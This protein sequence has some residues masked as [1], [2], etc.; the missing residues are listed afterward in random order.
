M[1]TTFRKRFTKTDAPTVRDYRRLGQPA[2]C[3]AVLIEMAL[4]AR[5]LSASPPPNELCLHDVSFPVSLRVLHATEVRLLVHNEAA[6]SQIEIVDDEKRSVHRETEA[7]YF[8][9]R[10]SSKAVD[11]SRYASRLTRALAVLRAAH[12]ERVDAD[13]IYGQSQD[14]AIELGPAYRTLRRVWV[15]GRRATAKLSLTIEPWPGQRAFLLHPALVEASLQLLRWL[16]VATDYNKRPRDSSLDPARELDVA[17][18]DEIIVWRPLERNVQC[19]VHKRCRRNGLGQ[20]LVSGDIYL[21]DEEDRPLAA[22]RGI[23]FGSANDATVATPSDDEIAR[24]F[25]VPRWEATEASTSRNNSAKPQTWLLLGLGDLLTQTLAMRLSETGC[26]VAVV[27]PGTRFEELGDLGYAADP[28]S[29]DELRRCIVDVERRLG[30]IDGVIHAWGV[31]E[32]SR[33]AVAGSNRSLEIF[34]ESLRLGAGSLIRLIQA[35]TTQTERHIDLVAITTNMTPVELDGRQLRPACNSLAAVARTAGQEYDQLKVRVLDISSQDDATV[36]AEVIVG[37]MQRRVDDSQRAPVVALRCHNRYVEYLEAIDISAWRSAKGTIKP[38][39]VYLITGGQRGLGLEVARWMATKAPCRLVLVNRT[40]PDTQTG[41][42]T[43]L[44]ASTTDEY[45]ARRRVFIELESMGAEVWPVAADV[46]D[47]DAMRQLFREIDT[48]YGRLDGIV[49]AAGTLRDRTIAFLDDETWD[50]VLRPKVR[51]SWILHELSKDRPL[52]FFVLFSSLISFTCGPGQANHAAANAF[53]DGLAHWRR[54]QGLPALSINWGYWSE[55]GVVATPDYR[56][57]VESKGVFPI[58]SAAGCRAFG[59][60]LASGQT[61][62]G[63]ARVRPETVAV[64]AGNRSSKESAQSETPGVTASADV[65]KWRD[66]GS[67]INARAVSLIGELAEEMKAYRGL[68]GELDHLVGV[69]LI[70][71]F[72]VLNCLP[73]PGT[74]R[75][76]ND[77]FERAGV[78]ATYRPLFE[79]L[80]EFLA[81]DGILLRAT[82]GCWK[83]LRSIEAV[84]GQ[85][86]A[87]L[88]DARRRYPQANAEIELLARCGTQLAD[89]LR[90]IHDP[91]EVLFPDGSLLAAAALYEQ[92]PFAR[93]Y[94]LLASKAVERYATTFRPG[95]R[96]RALEIGA[97]TGGT[98]SVLL[99]QQA[100]VFREYVYTDISPAFLHRGQ[101]RIGNRT[102][103]RFQLYN[104]EGSP[105]SQVLQAHVFDLVI[106]ANVLHATRAIDESLAH[107]RRLLA[108]G[109]MLLILETVREKRYAALTFA[110]TPGWWRFEDRARRATSPLLHESAWTLALADAGFIASQSFPDPT[111]GFPE[112][113]QRL[114]VALAP[115]GGSTEP[116][117][118]SST[119]TVASVE[120]R[121]HAQVAPASTAAGSLT[122]K[123]VRMLRETLAD[124]LRMPQSRLDADYPFQELGL[125]SLL[126]L[127]WIRRLRARLGNVRLAPPILFAHPTLRGLAAHLCTEQGEQLS[128]AMV[129]Q[130]V[131]AADEKISRQQSADSLVVPR[132]QTAPVARTLSASRHEDIAVVGYALRVP[133]ADN[134]DAFWRMLIDGVDAVGPWPSSRVDDEVAQINAAD[135]GQAQGGFLRDVTSFD[136]LFFRIS[137]TEAARME[138]RQRLFL[139]TA[140]HALEHAGYGGAALEG[141]RTGVFVGA[142]ATVPL[143]GCERD[144]IDEHWAS[145][146]TPSILASRIAYFLNLQGPVL[147]VDTACSSSLVALHLAV[148]SLR[149]A[150]CSMALAGGVHLNVRPLNFA[151]FERMGAMARDHR[152]KAFDERADGFVPG[153][154]VGSVVLRPLAEALA[155]GDT[156]YGVIK[157]SATNN[158]GRSNGL[159][160][161]N[162][163]A[164]R[165]VLL[166]AWQDAAVEPATVS[167]IEAHGTGTALGDPIEVEGI[168]L[169]FTKHTRRHQF[170]RIGAVKSN[171]GHAEPAAGMVS[172]IKV[173]LALAHERLPATLHLVEPNR[174]LTFENSPLLPCDRVVAWPRTGLPRRAGVSAFGLSGTNVHVVIEEAPD[175]TFAPVTSSRPEL[176]VLSARSEFALRRLVAAHLRSLRVTTATL[177][178]ICFTLQAG[179]LHQQ[180]RLAMVASSVGE[181]RAKLALLEP[182]EQ[183]FTRQELGIF[184][185]PAVDGRSETNTAGPAASAGEP[186]LTAELAPRASG[187]GATSA[188]RQARLLALAAR[189]AAGDTLDWPALHAQDT[190]RRR[191][192][193]PLYPFEHRRHAPGLKPESATATGERLSLNASQTV[194][195]ARETCAAVRDHDS[196]VAG[197]FHRVAWRHATIDGS[198]RLEP[199][200]WLIFADKEGVASNAASRLITLGHNVVLVHAGT[201]FAQRGPNDYVINPNRLDH[202]A[203]LVRSLEKFR[204]PWQGVVHAWNVDRRSGAATVQ[205][206]AEQRVLGVE[207]LLTAVQTVYVGTRTPELWIVT[208][209]TQAIAER[210][211]IIPERAAAWGF[212]RALRHELPHARVRLVDLSLSETDAVTAAEQLVAEITSASESNESAWHSHSRYEPFEETISRRAG[213]SLPIQLR[214]DATYLVTGGQEG[215]G[216]EIARWFVDQGCRRLVLLNRTPLDDRPDRRQGLS[217]LAEAGALVEPVRGD[218][219]DPTLL[220]SVFDKAAARGLPIAGV[221]HAAAVS[222]DRQAIHLSLEELRRVFKPKVCGAY[223]LDQLTREFG[224]DFLVLFS[225]LAG[226]FGQ[227]GQ[228]AY[229]AASS[230]L[231]AL[232]DARQSSA[233]P[234]VLSLAWGP[235]LDVGIAARAFTPEHLAIGGIEGISP[236]M[237]RLLFPAAFELSLAHLLVY[238][239][240]ATG[241]AK[242]SDLARLVPPWQRTLR[243]D[244]VLQTHESTSPKGF[245]DKSLSASADATEAITAIVVREAAAALGITPEEIQPRTNFQELGLDSMLAVRVANR[246]ASKLGVSLAPT[247]LFEQANVERL[248]RWLAD[249]VRSTETGASWGK[250]SATTI[251]D[252]Q[253]SVRKAPADLLARTATH[254]TPSSRSSCGEQ[255]VA[256]IGLACRFPGARDWRQYWSNQRRGIDTIREVP[257]D[258]WDWRE[259]LDASGEQLGT[260]VSR[261]GGFVDGVDKFD[262][263][264]FQLSPR[265]VRWMDPQQRLLLE[266]TWEAFETAGYAPMS[267]DSRRVGVFVGVSGVEYLH[268]LAGAG[269][270][271]D[272]HTGSGNSLTMVANRLSYFFDFVGPSLAIDTACSSSLVAVHQACESLA[273]GD[274]ELALAGGVNLILTPGGTII[275]S[276]AGMLSSS[277]RCRTFD[278]RADGYVRSEGAGLVLL[279][280]LDSALRDGDDIWAVIRGSAVNHDGHQK[281]GLTAPNPRSQCELLTSAWRRA[282]ITP[283]SL[284][285]FEAH[286]TG[287][288]LGDPLEIK[289]LNEA[290]DQYTKAKGHCAIG[291]AKSFIGH[292]EAAAG[293]AGLIRAVLALRRRELPPTIHF[294]A[295]NHAVAFEN[296]AVYIN[297]RLRE[298]PRRAFGARRAAVS[299]FG[300]GGTNA[301]L[302]LEEA[303]ASAEVSSEPDRPWHV[304]TLSAKRPAALVELAESYASAF[305]SEPELNI[306]NV[307]FTANTGRQSFDSRLAVVGQTTADLA[308]SLRQWLES[309]Q[310]PGS[311]SDSADRAN[312]AAAATTWSGL[313]RDLNDPTTVS[314]FLPSVLVDL[315]EIPVLAALRC[316]CDGEVFRTRVLPCLPAVIAARPRMEDFTNDQWRQLL[317][318]LARLYAHGVY[319]RWQEFDQLHGRRRIVLPTYPFARQRYWV[320]AGASKAPSKLDSAAIE[321]APSFIDQAKLEVDLSGWIHRTIWRPEP[322]SLIGASTKPVDGNWLVVRSSDSDA[323]NDRLA[324][325]LAAQLR[326][327]GAQAKL[328]TAVEIESRFVVHDSIDD[329]LSGIIYAWGADTHSLDDAQAATALPDDLRHLIRLSQLVANSTASSLA[330][331]V[332]T[333]GAHE[334]LGDECQ[335]PL[336]AAASGLARV[337]ALEC[338]NLHVASVDV[339]SIMTE[340]RGAAWFER[341]SAAIIDEI[342]SGLPSPEIA[343][344]AGNRHV[345]DTVPMSAELATASGAIG[346]KHR[347]VYLI[348]G[349]LGG[350]GL[351]LA[352]WLAQRYAARLVLVGRHGL[353]PRQDWAQWLSMH[354]ADD[355]STERIRAVERLEQLG[356][357]VVVAQSDVCDEVVMRAVVDRALEKFGRLDGVFHAAGVLH[358]ALLKRK[359][360]DDFAAVYRPKVGGALVLDH[361]T[362]D[363]ALDFT[364]YFSSVASL[365][366]NIFQADYTAASRV[367]DAIAAWRTARNRRTLSIDWGLWAEAGVAAKAARLKIDEQTERQESYRHTASKLAIDLHDAEAGWAAGI[368]PMSTQIAIAALE[369]A[370]PLELS[371]VVI[372][373]LNYRGDMPTKGIAIG[374]TQGVTATSASASVERQVPVGSPSAY[375][376]IAA[377]ID[378]L[379]ER[380]SRALEIPLDRVDPT[381]PTLDLGIDSILSAQLTRQLNQAAGTRF[382]R[383]LFFDYRNLEALATALVREHNITIALPHVAVSKS[384]SSETVEA[385]APSQGASSAPPLPHRF[386]AQEAPS[387]LQHRL[388]SRK[389]IAVIGMQGRFPRAASVDEY[390]R[391]L[392]DGVDCITDYPADRIGS[393]AAAQ[394]GADAASDCG[395]FLQAIDEFDPALF[396]LSRREAAEMDPQQRFLLEITWQALEKAGYGGAA[397][398]ATRTGVFVAAMA[399][400]YLAL[401]GPPAS[402]TYLATGSAGAIIASRVSF[403]LNLRGPCLTVDT[404]CS[405]ALVA[406][407]LAIESLRRG[408]SEFALVAGV[409]VGLS[410]LHFEALRQLRAISPSGRCRT[411]DRR[412]DGYVPGEGAAVV[413]LRPLEQAIANGD[414]VLAVIR[415]SALNHGGQTAGLT[416]P[417]PTAQAEVIRAALTDSGLTAD[418]LGYIEAH[419]TG[420]E[421]G[422]P[423]EFAG[424]SKAFSSDTSR[425]QFCGLGTVKTNIGHLEAAAGIAGLIKTILVLREREL[426]PNLHLCDIN[427]DIVA[428]ESPFF[429]LD[430]PRT[431]LV[432]A[433]V[434]RR[435]AVSSF[436]FGGTNAHVIVEEAPPNVALDAVVDERTYHLVN[437]SAQSRPQLANLAQRLADQV[438]QVSDTSLADACYTLRNGR[439]RLPERLAIVARDATTAADSL[440]RAAT[441]LLSIQEADASSV[442]GICEATKAPDANQLSGSVRYRRARP[443]YKPKV[444]VLFTGAMAAYP[445]MGR[446]LY[447]TEPKF[448]RALDWAAAELHP[449][450][451]RSLVDALYSPRPD[452]RASHELTSVP[453][454]AKELIRSTTARLSN[455]GD[456]QLADLIGIAF[457]YALHEMFR[458]WG[459]R[460]TAYLGHGLGEY[461]AACAAGV[462]S[463]ADGLRLVAYRAQLLHTVFPRS[464]VVAVH[465]DAAVVRDALARF[466][467]GLAVAAENAPAHTIVV[468]NHDLLN[469]AAA[470]FIE[471]GWRVEQLEDAPELHTQRVATQLSQ[472]TAFAADISHRSPATTLVSNL[473]GAAFSE[474][475][476]LNPAYWTRH[477]S[478]TIRFASGIESLIAQGYDA[479][480]ELGADVVLS[481]W[482]SSIARR[483]PSASD[484]CFLPAIARNRDNWQTVLAVLAELATRGGTIDWASFDEGRAR[485]RVELPTYP[486]AHER[487]WLEHSP[488]RKELVAP[489]VDPESPRSSDARSSAAK[490]C[491][492]SSKSISPE[493]R[494]YRVEWRDV[495][496]VSRPLP[497][498]KWLIFDDATGVAQHLVRQ[499]GARGISAIR[500]DAG[501]EF[502]RVTADS[503]KLRFD[504]VEDYARLVAELDENGRRPAVFVTLK[505]LEACGAGSRT[506]Q[507]LER[508]LDTT[509]RSLVPLIQALGAS[510]REAE[511]CVVT[512]GGQALSPA[513]E[514]NQDFPRITAPVNPLGAM[515]APLVRAAVVEYPRLA[516][517]LVDVP[518]STDP[519]DFAAALVEELAS[520]AAEGLIVHRHGATRLAPHLAVCDLS[521]APS[522]PLRSDGFYLIAGGSGSLGLQAAH[523][524]ISMAHRQGMEHLRLLLVSRTPLPAEDEWPAILALSTSDRAATLIRQVLELRALGAVVQP[525]TADLADDVA[526]RRAIDVAISAMGPVRGVVH[527]AGH[528]QDS[529]LWR[530]TAASVE[531]VLHAKVVGTWALDSATYDQPL[532]FFV[533]F[534]SLSALRG[535][536]G[537]AVYAAA[538]AFQDAWAYARAQR[539][540]TATAVNWGPWSQSAAASGTRYQELLRESGILGLTNAEGRAAF[541]AVLASI[542]TQVAVFR[543][544]DS[545][546]PDSKPS[547][548]WRAACAAA[549][550]SLRELL[551]ESQRQFETWSEPSREIDSLASAFVSAALHQAGL[552]HQVGERVTLADIASR[553]SLASRFRHH[554]PV[555]L[556]M[557]VKDDYLSQDA[558]EAYSSRRALTDKVLPSHVVALGS[559]FPQLAPHLAVLTR[560]GDRLGDILAG[561]CNPLALL[562]PHGNS[563]DIQAVYETSP[564]PALLS[565]VVASALR[566]GVQAAQVSYARH[567]VSPQS[568]RILEIGG[569]TG[570]TTRV[571]LEQLSA[572]AIG[573]VEYLFTDLSPTLVE[574]T[575][576]EFAGRSEIRFC[577]LDIERDPATQGIERETCDVIVAANVLH[578]TRRLD[579]SLDHC[580]SLLRPGGLLIVIEAV[581]SSRFG[582]LT[583]ALTDGWWRFDDAPLRE[584]TPL[585]N[586]DNWRQLLRQHGFGDVEV[587]PDSV[588][589]ENSSSVLA[590][591]DLR[592]FLA[593]RDDSPARSGNAVAHA[594]P[595][596]IGRATSSA[597]RVRSSRRLIDELRDVFASVLRCRADQVD[598]DL[599]FQDLGLDSLSALEILKL[600]SDRLSFKAL[601]PPL[602][603]AYPT[604]LQL[605]EYL[606]SAHPGLVATTDSPVLERTKQRSV[607]ADASTLKHNV[608]PDAGATPIA[609]I[610][611]AFRFP[612]ASSQDE[613][614]DHLRDGVDCVGPVP[615]QRLDLA[616]SPAAA[617][618]NTTI[619]TDAEGG[620]LEGV[621]AFDAAF[622]RIAPSE[623]TYLDPRQRQFLET[624]YHALEHAGYGGHALSGSRTGVFVGLGVQ[625]YGTSLSSELL[626]EYSATGTSPATLASRLAYFLDLRGP[627]VP[628]DTACSSSL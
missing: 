267:P 278:A 599:P 125:D 264:L 160:A 532:D 317:E 318:M 395:G 310:Q 604:I 400:E 421:L 570:G 598:V 181:L 477:G 212:A 489:E 420:T 329:S 311:S 268:L 152:A 458:E 483:S 410:P 98:S 552:F 63:I 389:D 600:L 209:D 49:H 365:T 187:S 206:L 196:S 341:T 213:P 235:W 430:R 382:P 508:G 147:T 614:W 86:T 54:A 303:P 467:S 355:V 495:P 363:L 290:F 36:Q 198:R 482:G 225:S 3:P 313:A 428:D 233:R 312:E 210:T 32:W 135:G 444:A 234:R 501:Q 488:L 255:P 418:S 559:R 214:R 432:P 563:D 50:S 116:A 272:P 370:L 546:R 81:A 194:S 293:I 35:I 425:R 237:G 261:W 541:E 132:K 612:H 236:A 287:T 221:V 507:E 131:H 499:L 347:G 356:A 351:A 453:D 349:G 7:T 285:Y 5:R 352:E 90:G 75:A 469:M 548:L 615:A 578:A 30:P 436:G 24:W 197:W 591:L 230:Y 159:T 470:E 44:S 111:N 289:G 113:G 142:G 440:R 307:C 20:S 286:G 545:I 186:P 179:R 322:L 611:M 442:T 140:Y 151:A 371:R 134:S 424:L 242:Q 398:T 519:S 259:S 381:Q 162:P 423:I 619:S 350:I 114:I 538:N 11:R 560:C 216:L 118:R 241:R 377:V 169:A 392:R 429:L 117:I 582:L 540:A 479:F 476:K 626:C 473:T 69:L 82:G 605:A 568:F 494:T 575:R 228:T 99:A 328:F 202:V 231:D 547:P 607:E 383:T 110:L 47:F 15:A 146:F 323:E 610:G 127:D 137:P 262:A 588:L 2:A 447:D 454:N 379:C 250:P 148:Q 205:E 342:A 141:S 177:A 45:A 182:W 176:F 80:L 594:P 478:S 18:I 616:R 154:A 561:R 191:V 339:D 485:R 496:T 593:R 219:A 480:I 26:R 358:N 171:V 609:V 190:P 468:G 308:Q 401:A 163:V 58:D 624:A 240:S 105:E 361:V 238:S 204:L 263:D 387:L 245:T 564:A 243:A 333:R 394:D 79:R 229:A 314:K 269:L 517:R 330:L 434:P 65:S 505:S 101:E 46:A 462:M 529:A 573:N 108:P 620:F 23:T 372:A 66:I 12:G 292:L 67:D 120:S 298:W 597:L 511:L 304:L 338:P 192:P 247:L 83:T 403:L 25:F 608:Q 282:G 523:S 463:W 486:F 378:W 95:T 199:G 471:R 40:S 246:L 166:S 279:K 562:F 324:D 41:R 621:A 484:V 265:E 500:V 227:H 42:G 93:F 441:A 375:P 367:L 504:Q 309:H 157:G 555:L 249:N 87:A 426:P 89:V 284:D 280:P 300:F 414:Q 542:P 112:T 208:S 539:G 129:G 596:F 465:A 512:A 391:N 39:G 411:F 251:S 222:A 427:P 319:V 335:S 525:A 207:S 438:Q 406:L 413:L 446:L 543:S 145:G 37:E 459:V 487:C 520:A 291:S 354:S 143:T 106:A 502:I 344:V 584:T 475:D 19:I 172:L 408:E 357:T 195:P 369:R 533:L 550:S 531:A 422:D 332:V 302:V 84:A 386:D 174:H 461:A 201:E 452:G 56:G 360:L 474:H 407:H 10:F 9:G 315:L 587:L 51:G 515:L 466:D 100:D 22:L 419:G 325:A 200:V 170:C 388:T 270:H 415:G 173:L 189:Y 306:A 556:A 138:P 130:A 364:V 623:A 294:D 13:L 457:A 139:E 258:R 366:G 503:Y 239:T 490:E 203:S 60:A 613:F 59:W 123:L 16:V 107:I 521:P 516:T 149:R 603:F 472:L 277:G 88:A 244:S 144:D 217:T 509:I 493:N 572:A 439:A 97:G 576:I 297:D 405:S 96:L 28:N 161:P 320:E 498:G 276:Q 52:D 126:A 14:K 1:P 450:L 530:H 158:D 583:F 557:L 606:A 481:D 299:S 275:C 185:G 537:H 373:R 68:D 301:H 581:E 57:A 136:P 43:T 175:P 590:G 574:R 8:Y 586:S 402:G 571:L 103:V 73:A 518:E 124:V 368:V 78:Q 579:N 62:L 460:A 353:P 345:P 17:S 256:V 396:R 168:T 119:P 253:S 399:S 91:V 343:F 102:N 412:A 223:L 274:A 211:L 85:S 248:S 180:H 296:S 6:A 76:G 569:G 33:S 437:L 115:G 592:L 585:L 337:V 70:D 53:L 417:N 271:L 156:I 121:Q 153:E 514:G 627:A 554:L 4:A 334:V 448:R 380:V 128:Q 506:R 393:F 295:P 443:R 397:L 595:R 193:L 455:L 61:H 589:G 404:A 617:G 602:L 374:G 327:R 266:L 566:D 390:W 524:L 558:P 74:T 48:R 133:G 184:A 38:H 257:A 55:T 27:R 150:E 218:V 433:G 449:Q 346:L 273:R 359:S 513:C 416:V 336:A 281:A 510:N 376:S 165:D 534:S 362:R 71:A 431:W 252:A 435:A 260:S 628:V 77:I 215:L 109:G 326:V 409:Q 164:Q 492:S 553:L 528:L 544:A 31:D 618:P 526:L 183:R 104:V 316:Y 567:G 385:L 348:T 445:E 94:N 232:A 92:S 29:A 565:R 283:D 72:S 21:V 288:A 451:G 64:R 340:S 601:T 224:C 464:A 384:A 522:L 155:N 577:V 527:A 551:P 305:E 220:R 625:D 34:S 254:A 456:F 226:T 188:D 122:E 491:S 549:H 167:Y 622:F 580:A 321:D 331:L 178:D 536:A 535:G 497:T